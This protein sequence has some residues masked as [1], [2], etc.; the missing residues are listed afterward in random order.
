[1]AR[2]RGRFLE[3]V[4]VVGGEA[5]VLIGDPA[6]FLGSRLG[7][8][9]IALRVLVHH[10]QR[11]S[12]AHQ[13]LVAIGHA[14]LTHLQIHRTRLVVDGR[15]PIGVQLRHIADVARLGLVIGVLLVEADV[16]VGRG[17][18]PAVVHIG[19]H[20]LARCLILFDNRGEG[21]HLVAVQHGLVVHAALAG[22]LDDA[23]VVGAGLGVG[24]AAGV[25]EVAGNVVRLVE[26]DHAELVVGS[27][28]DELAL[29]V[30]VV[31]HL[32]EL[33]RELA[34]L[35]GAALE[36]LDDL[37]VNIAHLVDRLAAGRVHAVARRADQVVGVGVVE[38]RAL[39][40][41]KRQRVQR[42]VE[43]VS[44]TEQRFG[45]G[46]L[47]RIVFVNRHGH[48]DDIGRGVLGSIIAVLSDEVVVIAAIIS[49]R[50]DGLIDIISLRGGYLIVN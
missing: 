16:L 35:D 34:G 17:V 29:G 5:H 45:G 2:R 49:T 21:D 38:R 37:R 32:D 48:L 44:I 22:V 4:Q 46:E 10:V 1:M 18:P 36:V 12:G 23:V 41:G 13:A 7:E 25:L 8:P 14:G 11:V 43:V 42:G 39:A 31:R 24:Q 26:V 47:S 6:A 27:G 19:A 20:Q 30:V 3:V 28:G 50:G 9:N 33:E 40:F 15:V